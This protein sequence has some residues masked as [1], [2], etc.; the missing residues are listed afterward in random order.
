MPEH[1]VILHKLFR[2][3]IHNFNSVSEDNEFIREIIK[4]ELY[5]EIPRYCRY[6]TYL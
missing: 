1:P 3:E 4:P 5:R 6:T 2:C